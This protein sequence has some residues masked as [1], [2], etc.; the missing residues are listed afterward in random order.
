MTINYTSLL[1]LAQ[2]VTGTESGTWGDDV[3]NGLT[4]YLDAAIAGAQSITTDAD[5]TLSITNGTNVSSNLGSTSSQYMILIC[6]G[7]R[8]AIRN[9]NVPNSS[10]VYVV[11]N[12]TTGGYGVNIRGV[13]GPTTGVTVV[14]G[15]TGFI[16]WNGSD[17]VNAVSSAPGV[18]AFTLPASTTGNR[19]T[20]S[21]GMLRFN[22][23]LT[24]FEGFDGSNW[25]GIGGAQA[26]GVIQVNKT[27][28][29]VSYTLP[30][31]SNGFSVGPITVASGVTI[32][33]TSGQRWVVI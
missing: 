18:G 9:I 10:K 23:S 2:P 4:A 20:G 22:T 3:N 24:Q 16:V 19:P 8:T 32:T 13:T 28:A 26:G 17:F 1:G 33:V 11:I 6:T 5:V 25:G 14:N 7:A 21:T 30:S 15:Q 12:N 31:G 29:T 27:N